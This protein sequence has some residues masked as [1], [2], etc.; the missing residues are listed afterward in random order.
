MKL[1]VVL[2]LSVVAGGFVPSAG[3]AFGWAPMQQLRV[4]A[5]VLQHEPV[6]HA[7]VNKPILCVNCML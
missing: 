1:A 3:L 6:A 4:T 5:F 2:L 7:L